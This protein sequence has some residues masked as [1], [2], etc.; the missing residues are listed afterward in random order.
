[1][2]D[3]QDSTLYNSYNAYA[4]RDN[5]V[6]I[7]K[8][9]GRL[10][11]VMGVRGRPSGSAVMRPWIKEQ[12]ADNGDQ[13]LIPSV[14][15]QTVGFAGPN[16]PDGGRYADG[17][18]LDISADTDYSGRGGRAEKRSIRV[19]PKDARKKRKAKS[20]TVLTKLGKI[21]VA[22]YLMLVAALAIFIVVQQNENRSA[23]IDGA[24]EA[25]PVEIVQTVTGE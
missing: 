18:S 3:I 20:G 1:M 22:I 17:L 5:G 14:E 16:A 6:V 13:I 24:G 19:K 7:N 12:T 11:E 25:K 9:H 23:K 8:N 10:D 15:R 2:N 21:I 4:S